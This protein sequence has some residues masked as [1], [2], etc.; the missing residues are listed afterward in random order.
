[1]V[2]HDQPDPV[3][4]AETGGPAHPH[5]GR[6]AA[7]QR[8]AHVVEAVDEG[9]VALRSHLGIGQLVREPAGVCSEGLE[10]GLTLRLRPRV[11]QG[12]ID[13]ER[14]DVRGVERRRSADVLCAQRLRPVLQPLSNEGFSHGVL[15]FRRS[16]P[17]CSTPGTQSER[18]D[19]PARDSEFHSVAPPLTS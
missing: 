16:W 10:P 5:L 6:V 15:L 3:D 8:A 18:G 14:D 9:Q 11:S 13:I 7:G 19:Q 4:P 2:V 17:R 1:M 12:R